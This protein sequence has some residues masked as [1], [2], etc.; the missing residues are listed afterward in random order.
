LPRFVIACLPA[1]QALEKYRKTGGMLKCK[2]CVQKQEENERNAA[3][4][5]RTKE[6][7]TQS[8]DASETLSC[9]SCSKVLD[10]SHYN[11]NQWNKG[12]GKA[13]CR[14]CVETSLAEERQQLVYS[15]EAKLQ[16]AK[17]KVAEAQASGNAHSILKAESE[18]AALEAEKVTGLKPIKMSQGGGGRGRGGRGRGRG[19]RR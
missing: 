16:A 17:D 3:S 15:Q 13:R 4:Q 11:K 8:G 10:A 19:C 9:Q 18:L 7:E 1:S 12:S 5:K 2:Q 6:A 14:T